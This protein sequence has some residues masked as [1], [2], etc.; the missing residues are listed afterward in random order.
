MQ[1]GVDSAEQLQPLLQRA[2][3]IAVGPG[4]GQSA[5]ANELLVAAMDSG[6]PL[7]VDAD[8][9]NLL[10]ATRRK[11]ANAVLTPHAGE[12][13]RL[14]AC[15]AGDIQRDRFA[16][17]NGLLTT[18]DAQAVVLKGNGTLVAD[19]VRAVLIDRGTPALATGGSGDVLTGTVAAFLARGAGFMHGAVCAA[20]VHAVAGERAAAGRPRGVTAGDVAE[21]IAQCLPH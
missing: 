10:A 15:R 21:A 3:C 13:A 4:L 9:L 19:K 8:G 5:W 7:V 18:Y 12:A 20:C 11:C 17:V 16:A 14:L 1:H 2:S 6:K